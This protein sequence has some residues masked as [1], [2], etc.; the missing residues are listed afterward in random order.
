METNLKGFKFYESYYGYTMTARN[1]EITKY[2]VVLSDDGENVEV[3]NLDS[4]Y[5]S[6]M[7]KGDACFKISTRPLL[8]RVDGEVVN[9]IVDVDQL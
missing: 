8:K 1:G 6:E 9:D 7:S 3:M 2:Y 5:K 4:K